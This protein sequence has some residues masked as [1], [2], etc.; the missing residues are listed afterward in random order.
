MGDDVERLELRHCSCRATLSMPMSIV[1]DAAR[2]LETEDHPGLDKS[3][4]HI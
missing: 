2:A 4:R 3:D 1:N